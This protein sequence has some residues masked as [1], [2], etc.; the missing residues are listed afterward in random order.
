MTAY[1][2]LARTFFELLGLWSFV[3]WVETKKYKWFLV[4][5]CMIGL[6][7][8]TKLLTVGSLGI[9]GILI[10][11]DSFLKKKT[12]KECL[13]NIVLYVFVSLLIPLPWFIFSFIH[14]G[15][16]IYP[17]FSAMYKVH[18]GNLF[19]VENFFVNVWNL[20][21]H[22]ADPVSP[23]YIMFLPLVLVGVW[24]PLP[25]E[26]GRDFLSSEEELLTMSSAESVGWGGENIK[27]LFLL[28][29]IAFF[30]FSI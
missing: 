28:F 30:P 29:F 13:G 3:N 22:A 12:I 23:V 21:T 14:T 16:P 5:A 20:F 10:I 15:S 9:F 8:T 19:N 1:V 27:R 4:S 6:A 25:Q 24:F 26:N 17:F 7:I 11:A 18:P 2:D